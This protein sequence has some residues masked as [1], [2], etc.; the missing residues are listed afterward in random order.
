MFNQTSNAYDFFAEWMLSNPLL[1]DGNPFFTTTLYNLTKP[2][3]TE[4]SV[5]GTY[6]EFEVHIAGGG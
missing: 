2:T 4:V 1:D 5:A 6:R 3:A